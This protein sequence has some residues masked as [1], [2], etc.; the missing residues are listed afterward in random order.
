[1]ATQKITLYFP[2]YHVETPVV[3]HLVKDYDL[4][5]NIFR[6]KVTANE[7]GFLVLELK[8]SQENIDK[9]IAHAESLHVEVRLNNKGLNWNGESCVGCTTCIPHCPTNALSVQD[10]VSM[11]VSFDS[12]KCVECLSCIEKCPFGACTSLF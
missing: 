1:M 12:D 10:R 4:D 9:G 5:V 8:G 7:E 11:V 6:A 2:Q 3:T